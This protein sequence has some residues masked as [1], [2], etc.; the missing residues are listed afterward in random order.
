M[1]IAAQM[2]LVY[3]LTGSAWLLGVLGFATQI[4]IFFLGPLGGVVSDSVDRRRVLIATQ[5]ASMLLAGTLAA[6]TLGGRVEVGHLLAVA[7]TLG[8]VNAFD[9]PTRQAFLADMVGK[10]D[11]AN[12]IA[13]N[14]SLFHAARL[15]GPAVGGLVIAGVGEGWCFVINT[16]SFMAVLA[17][18]LAI[19]TVRREAGAS[20]GSAVR[21]LFEGLRYVAGTPGVRSL[22]LL[23]GLMSLTGAS[24]S[25]LLPVFAREILGVEARGLGLLMAASGAGALT[26][27][28]VLATR[29]RNER[30]PARVAGAAAVAAVSL[31]VLSQSRAFALSLLALFPVG[32]GITTQLAGTNT[33][34]QIGVP[35]GL[36][37][38]VLSVYAMMFMGLAPVGA[39]M[40]GGLASS[41]GVAWTVAANGAIYLAGA[42]LFAALSVRRLR[43]PT[44]S[45]P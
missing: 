14:A 12:A 27:A 38:R 9:I 22:L 40:A 20:E 29:P 31:I 32:F 7:F 3:R 5:G 25:A 33:L 2:W 24:Y 19:D 26:A 39:L 17:S 15:L 10:A 37:G 34:L 44:S 11:V 6:L 36:R 28:L 1:Q 43:S 21:N 35:D 42:G 23:L 30:L 41:V 18:L 13:L 4:P 45:S 8:C 16:V